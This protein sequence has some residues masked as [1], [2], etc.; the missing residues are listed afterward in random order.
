[1]IERV[2]RPAELDVRRQG[3]R[4]LRARHRHDAALRAV[5]HRDRAAP[6]AL[7][8]HAP[9]AQ[10][11]A[12]L[13]RADAAP[14]ELLDHAPLGGGDVEAVQEIGVDQPAL[15]DVGLGADRKALRL[16]ARRQHHGYDRQA[17]LARELQIALVVRRTAENRA[18]AVIH[19]DEVG[20]VDRQL[21]IGHERIAAA[22]AG[23][24]ADL[25][26][27]LDRLL[28]GRHLGARRDERGD[29]GV[30]VGQ[31]DAQR[32]VGGERHEARA[33]Q[34]VGPRG[35]HLERL[36][37][38]DHREA[39]ARALGAADPPLLHQ[40]HL[41]R[42][43]VEGG[44]R[45][46]E[47]LSVFGDLE[48][49]LGELAALDHGARAP[50]P[51]FDHLLVGEHGLIDR[52][53][54]DPGLLAIDQSG[55]EKVEE[56]RLLVA[57]VRR[58]AG[59]DLARPVERQAHG[60]KLRAHLGDVG[61]GP[62]GGMHALGHRGVLRRQAERIPA[63]RMQH[64]KALRALVARDHVADRVV[65][66]VAHV[67]PAGR[68][69]EH[70]E[71]VVFGPGRIVRRLEGA[72]V[73]PDALPLGF[74]VVERVARHR[75]RLPPRSCGASVQGSRADNSSQPRTGWLARSRLEPDL[76]PS[77]WYPRRRCAARAPWSG[78][79][80]RSWSRSADRP[81]RRATRS[82]RRSGETPPP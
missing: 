26:R 37:P 60:L 67:N 64:G 20:D 55:F 52:V 78:C 45:V 12:H 14:L 43:A 47:L 69:G 31:L 13:A 71:H 59:R 30:L 2:A 1:M 72:P 36:R 48:E 17:V 10:P 8:R 65:A 25:L 24:V 75:R 53:P 79:C 80:P 82:R 29:A 16:F 19:Q 15:A 21:L 50:A 23:V 7:A 32:M 51:A 76:G 18:G 11:V 22:Q 54:V 6:V 77:C 70:L 66:H 33:E 74:G 28:A 63:H 42:P 44:Q 49:P 81:R 27:L 40:A 57:I 56:H 3:H 39:D 46:H 9:V 61:V 38:A 41:G 4:Q 35:E 62:R 58:V 68:I 5:D 34:G 73:L